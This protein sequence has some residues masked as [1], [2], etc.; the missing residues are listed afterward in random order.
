MATPAEEDEA[1]S[2]FVAALTLEEMGPEHFVARD[3][4]WWHGDRVFGG[5]TVS[6]ALRAAMATVA[7][8]LTPHSLH[9]YFLR[10]VPP[11]SV[12]DLN[13][14]R[15]R[16]GRTFTLRTVTSSVEDK[17]VFQMTCSF[18]EDEEG[19][20]YQ[21]A[22][23]DVPGPEAGEER[24]GDEEMPFAMRELG[25]T[26]VQSD[27]TYE[28][29]RRVW[30]RSRRPLPDDPALHYSVLAYMSDM[31]GASFRPMSLNVWGTHTDAS[32]DHALWFHRFA[33]AD[34][35][36]LYDLQAVVNAGG[37]STVR[38]LMYTREGALCMSMTQEL[39]IRPIEGA[40]PMVMPWLDDGGKLNPS[41]L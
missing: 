28:S 7:G 24:P 39:L 4:D 38:G 34:D 5:M 31:T 2:L 36:L 37:R 6:Q 23:P 8:P 40:V 27:G 12:I 21:L 19:D 10:P 26:P 22:M 41:A 3:P 11:A 29:T 9:G 32:L 33:R 16:D 20:E 30:F 25:P 17:P 18:H 1:E 13:V 35:W 14:D 15:V